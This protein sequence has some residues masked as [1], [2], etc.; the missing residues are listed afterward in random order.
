MTSVLKGTIPS[1]VHLAGYFG[2]AILGFLL[3]ICIY[4]LYFH[5]LSKYPGP[6]FARATRIYQIY[7]DLTGVSHL[8]I[9]EL[10]DRYGSVVRIA[11]NELSYNTFQA[12]KDICGHRSASRAGSF[13]KDP[14]FFNSL[15][16]KAPYIINAGDADHRRLRR[17]QSHA[18]SEKALMAQQGIIIQY[19]DLFIQR[20]HEQVAGESKGYVDIVQWYNFTT[21]DIIGDLAFGS[22]FGCLRDGVWHRWIDVVYQVPKSGVFLRAARRFFPPVKQLLLSLIPKNMVASR[23]YQ[24]EFSASRVSERL[25]QGT[26]RPDFM[27]YIL[28]E[29]GENGMTVN[30]LQVGAQILIIAGSETTATLLSGATYLLLCHPNVLEKLISEVRSSFEKESDIN[31]QSVTPLVY[32]AAVLN[33]SLRLYPPVP[34]SLPR[35]APK[36]GEFVCGQFVPA[37]TSLGV[38]QWSAYRS[39]SNFRDPHTF[40]PERWLGEERYAGDQRDA[41]QPFSYGPRNC[42]G[43]NLALMEMKVILCRLL[44]NFDLQLHPDSRNWISS[45]KTFTLWEKGPLKVRLIPVQH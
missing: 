29:N 35:T 43:K 10:H 4:N 36:P 21:F 32:L 40:V 1:P 41:L 14:T 22:S 23:K 17:L 28:R 44:W 6:F 16:N 24:Y 25:T 39:A 45:Q 26:E 33:E 42:L 31:M 30:E 8:K 34:I 15:G 13:E 38:H 20:L 2:L 27:S 7:W 3:S 11:P 18:F 9:K 5:P 19:V 37:G 12:W